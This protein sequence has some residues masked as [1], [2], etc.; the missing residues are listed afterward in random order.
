MTH[1][2]LQGYPGMQG[3]AGAPGPVGAAVKLFFSFYIFSLVQNLLVCLFVC[4][5]GLTNEFVRK[6]YVV[7]IGRMQMTDLI[8]NN[9]GFVI[10]SPRAS[11]ASYWRWITWVSNCNHPITSCFSWSPV[12]IRA[13][14]PVGSLVMLPYCL[15]I[16]W[17]RVH[18]YLTF[19]L[20]NCRVPSLGRSWPSW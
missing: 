2:P 10:G 12:V 13:W 14:T 7:F 3:G 18:H 1:F 8:Y 11:W 17:H 4:F 19:S 15:Q 9:F 5:R 20:P 16:R 6:R